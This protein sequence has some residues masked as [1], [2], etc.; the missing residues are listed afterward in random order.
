MQWLLQEFDDTRKLAEALER[1]GI[2]YSWHKVVPFVGDLIPEPVVADRNAVVMFGSYALWRN[3]EANGYWPGVFRI[4]AFV[5]QVAWQPFMLNG[6]NATML[7]VRDIPEELGDDGRSW[8]V[9]P[10]DDSKALSGG[11]KSAA[12]I[13]E[14]ARSVLTLREDEIPLGSLRHD[15]MLMLTEPAHI[16]KEWRI[17]IVDGNVV[18]YSLYKEGDRVTYR[19]EIDDDAQAF[20]QRLAALNPDYARAYVMDICR[21]DAGLRLLETNCINAAGFYAADIMKLAATIDGL[22]AV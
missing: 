13:R 16:A 9:R 15:T 10:V 21:T 19:H 14:I 18:T 6:A 17:W 8:F 2:S 20:A 3:A 11:V 5:D 7:A 22:K 12:Q 4:D 1:L